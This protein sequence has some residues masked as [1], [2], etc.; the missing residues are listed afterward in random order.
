M[1][2]IKQNAYEYMVQHQAGLLA[3]L[4]ELIECGEDAGKISEFSNHYLDLEPSL[5]EQIK[6]SAEYMSETG[7]RPTFNKENLC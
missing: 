6:L 7:T 3:I 1:N 5:A 4:A 2:D